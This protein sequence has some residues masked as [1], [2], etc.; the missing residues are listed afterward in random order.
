MKTIEDSNDIAEHNT[1]LKKV[2]IEFQA[3]FAAGC[4]LQPAVLVTACVLLVQ[5]QGLLMQRVA[6]A[7]AEAESYLKQKA[8]MSVE[9]NR[10]HSVIEHLRAQL[11][12]DGREVRAMLPPAQRVIS[13]VM[14]VV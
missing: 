7:Q 5:V 1:T 8:E 14:F 12:R 6:E 4:F 13:V 2:C 3:A 11:V 9:N 10:L